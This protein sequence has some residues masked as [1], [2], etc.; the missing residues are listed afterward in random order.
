VPQFFAVESILGTKP[1]APKTLPTF[2]E[3]NIEYANRHV[4]MSWP[5]RTQDGVSISCSSYH[6][7]HP[8]FLNR[9][10]KV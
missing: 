9:K 2:G 3:E 6:R 7:C 4:N 5:Q 10:L 1:L 8:P